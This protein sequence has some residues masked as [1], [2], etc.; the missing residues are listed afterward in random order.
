MTEDRQPHKGIGDEVYVEL[1]H[2]VKEVLVILIEKL[3]IKNKVK[4]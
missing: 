4:E 2:S 1:I 3:W